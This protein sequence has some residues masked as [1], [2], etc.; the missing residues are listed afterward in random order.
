MIIRSCARVTGVFWSGSL[1]SA[2]APKWITL[3]AP[4]KPIGSASQSKI[5]ARN[6]AH[7]VLL[8][9]EAGLV[10]INDV[11]IEMSQD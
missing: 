9:V 8:A 4:I 6:D 10:Q 11:K 5:G 2:S 3:G 1:A 7:M